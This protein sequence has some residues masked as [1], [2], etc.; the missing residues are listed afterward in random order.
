M[1]FNNNFFS[2][3]SVKK[4]VLYYNLTRIIS[5][6]HEDRYTFLFISRCILLRMR[7]VSDKSCRENQNTQFVFGNIF[8]KSRHLRD[9]EEIYGTSGQATDDNIARRMRCA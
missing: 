8:R 2:R 7:N 4:T 1:E 3:K 5:T 9:N 6:L